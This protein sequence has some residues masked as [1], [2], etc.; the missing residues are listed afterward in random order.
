LG[1]T[2]SFSKIHIILVFTAFVNLIFIRFPLWKQLENVYMCRSSSCE[3]PS[4]GWICRPTCCLS[5]CPYTVDMTD[6]STENS[7][8]YI[9][10]FRSHATNTRIGDAPRILQFWTDWTAVWLQSAY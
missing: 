8:N 3:F 1:L 6:F 4:Y 2:S 7:P 10:W 9:Q 5:K